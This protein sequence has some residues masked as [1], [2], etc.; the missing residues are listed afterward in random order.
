MLNDI[1]TGKRRWRF[2][3]I[4]GPGEKGHES[5]PGDSWMH[6][7]GP[8]W[9]TGSYDPELNLIIWGTGNPSP[10]RTAVPEGDNL[11]ADSAIALDADSGK[12]NGISTCSYSH[13]ASD[14][15][16]VPGAA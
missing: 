5:W 6:G 12:L 7:G 4:P 2:W 11:Y 3:T 10:D 14:A 16:Q 1:K 15:V 9:V 8:T 13:D